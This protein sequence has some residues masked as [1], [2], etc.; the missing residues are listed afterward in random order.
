M[1]PEYIASF[2]SISVSMLTGLLFWSL[3]RNVSQMDKKLDTLAD[4][5][6]SLANKDSELQVRVAEL[7][8]RVANVETS[9]A[10]LRLVLDRRRDEH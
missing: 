5:V 7:S 2:I 8:V 3:Q 9:V 1:P 4:K 10:A 6:D